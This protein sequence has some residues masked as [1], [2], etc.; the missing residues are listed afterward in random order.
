MFGQFL[1][2]ILFIFTSYNLIKL[3]LVKQKKLIIS[4]AC[5]SWKRG[6]VQQ[7]IKWDL[8]SSI[9]ILPLKSNSLFSGHIYEFN[10]KPY[11]PNTLVVTQELDITDY[12]VDSDE[13]ISFINMKSKHYGFGITIIE[14]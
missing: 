12:E 5:M 9:N 10:N 1:S 14:R 2:V 11:K 4:D 8:V 3:I 13:F 7:H 6:L